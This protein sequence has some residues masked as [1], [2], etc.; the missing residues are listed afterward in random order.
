[1]RDAPPPLSGLRV[2]DLGR[3]ISAPYCCLLLAD[4]G[5]EVIRVE[6]P[7]GDEDRRL[8]LTGAHGENF[9]FPGL[10]R[11]KK[12]ITLDLR[13]REARTVLG[14][15]SPAAMSSCTTSVRAAA[16][17]V[18]ATKRFAPGVTT[19]SIP[20]C[21]ATAATAHAGRPGFD[22]IAQTCS[23]A[24]A[25]SGFD[26][27]PPLRSGVPWVDQ[28]RIERGARHAGGASPS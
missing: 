26:G 18:C 15:P 2:L 10:A 25:L 7:G 27:D 1:M 28:H 24:S 20:P 4:M 8:G 11:N 16:Q 19:S 13:Q 14:D 5:A 23:G 9:T 12:G 6:R 17:R 22:P 3:F 21:R